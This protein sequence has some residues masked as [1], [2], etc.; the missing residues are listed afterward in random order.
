MH[1]T[2]LADLQ[3]L[4]TQKN[5]IIGSQKSVVN[6]HH[7]GTC[8]LNLVTVTLVDF[9]QTGQLRFYFQILLFGFLYSM[10][11]LISLKETMNISVRST[12]M[13]RPL[14]CESMVQT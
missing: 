11:R 14:G 12:T 10:L 4:H 1:T 13:S 8:M 9:F 5:G 3:S 2:D 7:D 6:I